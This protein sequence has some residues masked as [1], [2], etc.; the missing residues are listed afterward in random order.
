MYSTRSASRSTEPV[1]SAVPDSI[2]AQALCRAVA[3]Y[4]ILERG[5]EREKAEAELQERFPDFK[6]PTDWSSRVRDPGATRVP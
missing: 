6:C 4:K 1:L 3:S 5:P 2:D